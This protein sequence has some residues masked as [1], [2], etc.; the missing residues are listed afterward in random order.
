MINIFTYASITKTING[1]TIGCSGAILTEDTTINRYLITRDSTNNIAEVL[2][3]KLAVDLALE[4]RLKEVNIWADSQFAIFGL[5]TWLSSWI[6]NSK[7]NVLYNSSGLQVKNQQLFLGIVRTIIDNN[8]RVNF[9]HIKGHV[10]N[11]ESMIH[12]KS[13]FNRVHN[14]DISEDDLSLAVKMNNL[15]D[16]NTRNLLDEYKTAELIKLKRGWLQ[17]IVSKEDLIRYYSLVTL[18]GNKL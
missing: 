10:N 8:L 7:N 12:A 3:V 9:F 13:V 14:A 15:V 4:L 16:N 1:E 6:K 5:T 11:Q 18:G 17:P 2:A